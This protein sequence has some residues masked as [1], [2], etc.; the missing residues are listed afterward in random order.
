MFSHWFLEICESSLLLPLLRYYDRPLHDR[1]LDFLSSLLRRYHPQRGDDIRKYYRWFLDIGASACTVLWEK[2]SKMQ[3]F[4]FLDFFPILCVMNIHTL[5]WWDHSHIGLDLDETLAATMCWFL[6]MAHMM[7]K[8][9]LL[10]DID[11]IEKYEL[12]LLDPSLSVEEWYHLWATY[13][14]ATMHP[15]DVPLVLWAK[16]WV[17]LLQNQKKKLSIITARSDQEAWKV[18][19]TYDWVSSHFPSIEKERIYFVNHFSDDARPKSYACDTHGVTLMIDDSFENARDLVENGISCILLEKPWNRK[20][21]FNHPL[22]Y[23]AK[24]WAEIIESLS[25]ETK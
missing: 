14:K 13:G 15:D 7:D 8:L 9:T 3:F 11:S 19:R 25:H 23:R 12:S 6:D 10:K 16:E 17:S 22:L 21:S 4:Y 2:V 18:Q 20:E 5:P 24:D 1:F